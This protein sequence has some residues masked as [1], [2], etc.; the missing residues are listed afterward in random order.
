MIKIRCFDLGGGGLKTCLF[1]NEIPSMMENLGKA[2]NQ[3]I[4]TWIRRKVATLDAEV[5]D[6]TIFSFS[7]AG[8]DKLPISSHNQGIKSNSESISQHFSLPSGRVFTQEDSDSH[9]LASRVVLGITKFPQ[10]NFSIGT[11]IG[12]GMY[13][14]NGMQVKLKDIKAALGCSPWDLITDSSAS[15]KIAYFALAKDGFNE[16][17]SRHGESALAKFENRWLKFLKHVFLPKLRLANWVQ[18]LEITLTGG[19][20]DNNALW[21]GSYDVDGSRIQKG[22]EQAG[23]LGARLYATQGDAIPSE[24]H[25]SV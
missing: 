10:L 6:G 14:A 5:D 8:L 12:C 25:Q 21:L 4:A 7:L 2:D 18:P 13:D 24:C 19:I 23:L 11:G 9:L 17:V 1:A 3:P 15:Q 22:P 16:L 20:V